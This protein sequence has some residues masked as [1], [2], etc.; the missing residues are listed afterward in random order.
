M[1]GFCGHQP[2]RDNT[3]EGVPWKEERRRFSREFKEEAARLCKQGDR[4]IGEITRDMDLSETTLRRW[5]CHYDVGQ[6]QEPT[7][8]L[9]T[10]ERDELRALRRRVRTDGLVREAKRMRFAFIDAEKANYRIRTMCRVLRVSASGDYAHIKRPPSF[11][12]REEKT[13]RLRSQTIHS[14]SRAT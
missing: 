8:G 3:P 12:Q 11:R 4:S 1:P 14:R 2:R 5:V 7:V 10:A 9:T 6:S 13:L